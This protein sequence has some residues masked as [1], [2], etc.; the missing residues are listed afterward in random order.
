M[1][2]WMDGWMEWKFIFAYVNMYMCVHALLY[3]THTCKEQ[4]NYHNNNHQQ[5]DSVTVLSNT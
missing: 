5:T 1:D 4:P 3:Y 2:G